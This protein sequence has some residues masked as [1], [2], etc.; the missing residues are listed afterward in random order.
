MMISIRKKYV[1]RV[2]SKYFD[3]LK[4]GAARQGKAMSLPFADATTSKL[5]PTRKESG[6][7]SVRDVNLQR[8]V[9]SARSH[10]ATLVFYL[11]TAPMKAETRLFDKTRFLACVNTRL[12]PNLDNPSDLV[13]PQYHL[14]RLGEVQTLT[15]YEQ[16]ADCWRQWD[17]SPSG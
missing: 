11:M 2:F 5:E 8:L 14:R 7:S 13:H 3:Y 9:T 12:C 10:P 17:D 15:W 4:L 1:L 16:R 6:R